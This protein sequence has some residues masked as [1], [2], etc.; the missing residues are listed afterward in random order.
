ME[1][2]NQ[3]K[4][5]MDLVTLL[6]PF[7]LITSE[8]TGNSLLFVLAMIVLLFMIKQPF[9]IFP[10]YFIASLSSTYFSPIAGLGAGRVISILL[11]VSLLLNSTTVNAVGRTKHTGIL[12]IVLIFY[13][14]FST[15]FS[16]SG[17]FFTF[18]V[19]LQNLLVLF[20]IQRQNNVNVEKLAQMLFW[21]SVI[22]LVGI[23][24]QTISSGVTL[25]TTER[26][27]TEDTNGNNFAMM[28]A[29]L[30]AIFISFFALKKG[31]YYKLISLLFIVLAIIIIF[32]SGSRS[33][34]IG[35][36][37]AL[38]VIP[39]ISSEG[40]SLKKIF[41]AV[42]ILTPVYLMYNYAME[43]DLYLL[44]RFTYENVLESG[45]SGRNELMSRILKEIVPNYYLFGVGIGGLNIV[46]AGIPKPCHN[47]IFDPLSQIGIVGIVLYWSMIIPII[48]NAFR[49]IKMDKII[50][51][52]LA[53]FI[54]ALVNGI[55]ETIFY[56]K[57]FW[58]SISLCLV[59]S[60]AIVNRKSYEQI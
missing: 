6:P 43:S 37:S 42:I 45:G 50:L 33:S 30:G 20:F 44:K 52:P 26:Y 55:G 34:L 57:F 58:N 23:A 16:L 22:V 24:I 15:L 48:G 5:V 7:L 27:T 54:T 17:I 51:L 40:I 11:I 21:S 29:Q 60:Q 1:F 49:R 56:E 38:V 19:M 46:A 53:L 2:K 36:I 9:N 14:L 10:S 28:C 59:F 35:L 31:I 12:C 4:W 41:L 13:N 32:L 47:I 18:Y 8:V 39:L 25:D 3:N